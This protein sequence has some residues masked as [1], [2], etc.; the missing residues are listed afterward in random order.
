MA[1]TPVTTD[2]LRREGFVYER[3][4]GQFMPRFIGW[5]DDE[6]APILAIEDLS[7]TRWPPPWDTRSVEAVLAAD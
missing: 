1:T 4:T 2:H 6:D 5:Q 7:E 3:L